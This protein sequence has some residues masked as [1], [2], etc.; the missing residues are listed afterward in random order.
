VDQQ[1]AILWIRCHRQLYHRKKR[2]EILCRIRKNGAQSLQITHAEFAMFW[3]R[4]MTSLVETSCQ[5]CRH[6]LMLILLWLFRH[7]WQLNKNSFFCVLYLIVKVHLEWRMSDSYML[8]ALD[9]FVIGGVTGLLLY[10]FVF[11]KKKEDVPSFKKLTT[12]YHKLIW[13]C[14][15]NVHRVGILKCDITLCTGIDVLH[16]LHTTNLP[17]NE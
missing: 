10:Y 7:W 13:F 3:C 11:R 14:D 1:D 12:G 5:I 9:I 16:S 17:F 6:R 4:I 8:G 15:I 2:V